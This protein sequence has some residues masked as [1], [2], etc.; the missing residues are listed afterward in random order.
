MRQ[1]SSNPI[2]ESHQSITFSM[3]FPST[4]PY[5]IQ[6][7]HQLDCY[8]AYTRQRTTARHDY[9]PSSSGIHYPPPPSHA[10]YPPSSFSDRHCGGSDQLISDSYSQLQMQSHPTAAL[11][12]NPNS[13]Q[14]STTSRND[15]QCT[16]ITAVLANRSPP[17][18]PIRCGGPR[19]PVLAHEGLP[20]V[21]G[22][23]QALGGWHLA[24]FVC[25]L[26]I[27]GQSLLVANTIDIIL[28][29]R[30]RATAIRVT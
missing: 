14:M 9:G 24:R 19:Q 21:M 10:P 28:P 6:P 15:R 3:S 2:F 13:G 17:P 5:L 4:P 30:H 20:V 1:S 12:P 7:P 18:C 26:S 27:P 16:Q 22:R 11:Q 29:V 25:P 23:K 8:G